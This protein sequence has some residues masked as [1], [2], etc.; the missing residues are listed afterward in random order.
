[1]KPIHIS[2]GSSKE[3]RCVIRIGLEIPYIYCHIKPESIRNVTFLRDTG[4]EKRSNMMD[5]V[6]P[7]SSLHSFSHFRH[8]GITQMTCTQCTYCCRRSLKTF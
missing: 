2:H 7:M 5:N 1:M 8:D 3:R 4:E 6:F